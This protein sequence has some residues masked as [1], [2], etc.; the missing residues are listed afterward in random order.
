MSK[1]GL[2][3]GIALLAL[4]AGNAWAG[5]QMY[6][7][8]SASVRSQL[9]KSVSD[10][11][12]E[13]AAFSESPYVQAWLAEMSRRLARRI[14]DAE[15]REDFLNT[16]HY[17]ATRAGLDPELMLGLIEVESGF[18]K[19]AVSVVG[20]RGFTQVMPFWIKTIGTRDHNLFHLRTNLRYGAT[21]LRH[22]LDI[23]RGNLFRAL[24]RYNGS[25]GKAEYPNMVRAAWHKHWT[26]GVDPKTF[27]PA[28]QVQAV[29][30]RGGS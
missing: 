9:A 22:Y 14:P 21:I 3:T 27:R 17:E 8:M 30:G 13:N 4:L 23:E 25:L 12:V 20:A 7:P 24:G 26:F 28:R 16:L 29:G 18:K 10:T 11:A 5:A 15:F 1:L 6:E 2:K 19:Y